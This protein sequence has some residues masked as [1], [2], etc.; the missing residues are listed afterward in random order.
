MTTARASEGAHPA[1]STGRAFGPSRHFSRQHNDL[2]HARDRLAPYKRIRRLEFA[3]LPKHISGKIRRV[4]LRKMEAARAGEARRPA[5]F[6]EEDL[7]ELR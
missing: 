6:W 3:E 1:T 7:A 4:D 5:A 2:R